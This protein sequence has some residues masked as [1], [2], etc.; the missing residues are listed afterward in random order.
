MDSLFT[1]GFE[2]VAFYYQS[3]TVGGPRLKMGDT[4]RGRMQSRSKKRHLAGGA[5]A[6]AAGGAIGK[7]MKGGKGAAI[8]AAT[9][10]A[11]SLASRYLNKKK[12]NNAKSYKGSASGSYTYSD[13]GT[14]KLR[15]KLVG[16]YRAHISSR[17]QNIKG[18]EV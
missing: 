11:A 7:Y 8:G 3:R 6:A 9:G 1:E 4:V 10:A 18:F 5:A 12:I 17:G 2:K 16:K 13:K 14:N 15:S